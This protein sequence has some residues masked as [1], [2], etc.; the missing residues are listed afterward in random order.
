MT[1]LD[2]VGQTGG[3]TVASKRVDFSYDVGSRLSSMVRDYKP[4][5]TWTEVAT[6]AFSYDTINRLTGSICDG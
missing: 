2:Q 5:G 6:S 1:R 3:N 4:S